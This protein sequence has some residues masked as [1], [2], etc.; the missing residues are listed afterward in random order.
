MTTV[1]DAIRESAESLTHAGI[2]SARLEA[3]LFLGF[4][5]GVSPETLLLNPA[6]TFQAHERAQLELLLRRRI[7]REPIAYILGTRE[8]WSLPFQVTR[9][10]LVPRPETETVVEAALAHA[11]AAPMSVLDLGTG[12]GCL[13]LA[14]LQELQGAHGVGV[15]VSDAALDVARNNACTL[16]FGARARFVNSLWGDGIDERF[17]VIV[18]NPPYIATSEIERLSPDVAKFEP[19]LALDGGPDGL[20][21]YRAIAPRLAHMLAPGG[22]VAFEVGLGQAGEVCEILSSAGIHV[23][24][25]KADLGGMP[26]CVVAHTP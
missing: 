9:D 23:V 22:I 12:S 5:L 17:D 19:R 24:A 11:P 14:L 16:G 4:V 20:D 15:D 6:R 1:A 10:T 13:L 7:A 18:S 8:F 25:R 26:R 2:E 21:H 3:R